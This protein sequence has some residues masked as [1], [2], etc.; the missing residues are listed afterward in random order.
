M[1]NKDF[2]EQKLDFNM[3]FQEIKFISSE[4][5]PEHGIL[6]TPTEPYPVENI[7]NISYY[8][9]DDTSTRLPFF[10]TVAGHFLVGPNFFTRRQGLFGYQ[11]ILTLN[12]SCTMEIAGKKPFECTEGSLL[13]LDCRTKHYY[14]TGEGRTW[15]YKHFHFGTYCAPYLVEQTLGLVQTQGSDIEATID[16]I[17]RAISQQ[18]PRAPYLISDMISHILT[19]VVFL[20]MDAPALSAHADI[21][22]KAALYLREHFNENINVGDLAANHFMSKYYFIKLFTDYYGISPYAYLI[23][24][25]IQKAKICLFMNMSIAETAAAC[26]FGNM[27]NLLQIKERN[28]IRWILL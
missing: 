16:N 26:G 13:I 4:H 21:L 11:C 20:Q 24:Y 1:A 17:F 12:G 8:L 9:P 18:R 19:E 25:R 14:H 6:V 27:N 10:A 3:D 23:N 5:A 15:Q 22:E 7:P 28:H 2:Y